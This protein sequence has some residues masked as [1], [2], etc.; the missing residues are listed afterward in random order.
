ML[1]DPPAVE[2]AAPGTTA[3]SPACDPGALW[4]EMT[5]STPARRRPLAGAAAERGAELLDAPVSGGVAGAEAGTLTIMLGGAAALRRARPAAARASS[6]RTL[7]HVG[8]RPGDGDAAKTINNMLSATNLAAVAEALSIGLRAGL[9]PE[10]LLELRQRRHRRLRRVAEQ[11]RRPGADRPLRVRLHDRPVP[12]GP[13][14]RARARRSTTTSRPRSTTRPAPS[15]PR[16]RR[17]A[18]ETRTTPASTDHI[19]RDAGLATPWRATPTRL[20]G[21]RVTNPRPRSTSTTWSARRG[22]VLEYHKRLVGADYEFARAANDLVDAAYLKR[23]AA[24]PQDQGAHL[25]HL[26][27]RDARRRSAHIQSHIRVALELGCSPQE[28]LEAIEIALPEAGSS[29]SRR[30]SRRGPRSSGAP[31]R[32]SRPWPW[33]GIAD[34]LFC[35]ALMRILVIGAGGVG[36]AAAAIARRRGFFERM[37][38]A[39][40]EPASARRP[41]SRRLGDDRFGAAPGRRE[42]RA[43]RSSRWPAPSAPT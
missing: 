42:R 12:Q 29:R 36:A 35:R 18:R 43:R 14:D 38:L 16:T 2:G 3:C 24:G 20:T 1:P 41:P 15:G 17:A 27:D 23:A 6:A 22:Y 21:G 11:G 4:L 39:D 25:H 26:P 7:V 10:R 8:D 30:A 37:V 33:P 34:R 5:S 13:A 19:V 31:S 28:I 32:S 40:L 9:D